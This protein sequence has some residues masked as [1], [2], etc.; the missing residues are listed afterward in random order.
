MTLMELLKSI[1]TEPFVIIFAC[2]SLVEIAP[3]KI[4]PW[5]K[6]LKWAGDMINHN[7]QVELDNVRKE[8][9]DLKSDFE[10]KKANDM[11]WDILSFA[12]SCRRGNSHSKDEWWHC[13]SQLKEYEEY[14]EDKGIS[15]GVI[16]EDAHY[17]RELYHERNLKNDFL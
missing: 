4:N 9:S 2:L 5:S 7:V 3:I 1:V 15:N 14:T 17:L 8:L 10:G 6:V 16:D 13:M 12:N 11:R